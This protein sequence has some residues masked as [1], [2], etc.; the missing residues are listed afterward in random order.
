MSIHKI[1][2]LPTRVAANLQARKLSL[3][4]KQ[5]GASALEYLVLAAALIAILTVLATSDIG[6]VEA[7]SGL[8][9]DATTAGD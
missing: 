6:V 8:F 2:K 1:N 5:K 7:F 3:K 4:S 9:T